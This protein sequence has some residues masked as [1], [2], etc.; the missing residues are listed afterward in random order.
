MVPGRHKETEA[1]GR[2]WFPV[3]PRVPALSPLA[4]LTPPLRASL[5]TV[6]LYL[7]PS[8][9]LFLYCAAFPSD[10][11]SPFPCLSV[12]LSPLCQ[13]DSPSLPH[14]SLHIS[15]HCLSLFNLSIR[16]LSLSLSPC[17]FP[18]LSHIPSLSLCLPVCLS[19]SV[20]PICFSF[21]VCLLISSRVCL[22]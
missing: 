9:Y 16:L 17:L 6:H 3:P 5:L 4:A 8:A 14:F 15:L 18:Q 1:L 12:C 2:A 21:P 19:C 11:P 22:P 7:S 20:P 10:F 13:S